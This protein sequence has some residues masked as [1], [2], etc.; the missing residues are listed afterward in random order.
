MLIKTVFVRNPDLIATDMDGA[1]VMMSIECGEYY[2]STG[3]GPG[4]GCR[5]RKP[6]PW[7][8]WLK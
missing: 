3:G 4:T 2:D 6:F 1:A 8:V 5:W 7:W